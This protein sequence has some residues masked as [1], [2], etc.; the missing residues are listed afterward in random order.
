MSVNIADINQ[1]E[2][3]ENKAMNTTVHCFVLIARKFGVDIS[4][5]RIIHDYALDGEPDTQRLLRIAQEKGFKGLSRKMDWNGLERLGKAFPVLARL[6]NGNSVIIAGCRANESGQ[7]GEPIILILDPLADKADLLHIERDRF[8]ASWSGEIILLKRTYDIKNEERPFG[9]KWFIPE[10]HRQKPLFIQIIIVALILQVL[11]LSSPI[12]FQITFD[13]VIA[14]QSYNT[15]YVLSAGVFIALTFNMIMEYLRGLLLLHATSKIDIRVATRTFSKLLSLPISFFHKISAGVLTKHMQQ[16]STVRDFLT[17]KLFL[18]CLDSLAL[19]VYLPVLFFY[20]AKM[21][22]VVLAFTILISAITLLIATPYRNRLQSL[23]KAEGERQSMLVESISGMETLKSLSVEPMIQHQWDTHSSRSVS[24]SMSVGKISQLVSS[25]TG[26][27][28]KLMSVA[29]IFVGALLVFEGE[30]S[31]G[32]LI[33]FNMLAGK[34]SAP[35]VAMV[36]LVSEYQQTSLSLRML[37]EVMNQKSEGKTNTGLTPLIR[38]SIEFQD[39]T[40][41]YK[42]ESPAA[43]DKMS[44]KVNAGDVIGIVGRSGSG[45]STIIRLLQGLYTLE[46]GLIKV[47]G[48]DLREIEL[49]HF[50]MNT[51]VVLQ[52]SFLFKGSVRDNIAKARPDASFD[53]IIAVARMAGA[54][55]FIQ[56]LSQGYDT[57]LDEGA[58]NLSGGQRQRLSIARTLLRHPKILIFDEATSALDPESEQII[59]HNMPQISAGRTVF[60]AAHRLSTLVN[61]DRILVIDEGEV[62]DFAPHSVLLNRCEL[63]QKLWLSQNT[64]RASNV[65]V[66]I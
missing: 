29:L 20:S 8:E 59:Q 65:K 17:G 3:N 19:V 15:L 55:E 28:E 62:I 54:N 50:R 7:E 27:L 31:L 12:F 53:E 40:F 9:F 42:R 58:T 47:D 43:L 25:V 16:A 11:A 23:Y 49:T 26:Y 34:V 41:R 36:R 56:H 44:F 66:A 57:L 1:L 10:I 37:A 51:G 45:K 35:L 22:Y 64:H 2:T 48:L 52:E 63:Y 60:L 39:V 6:K 30:V 4:P 61:T 21:T 14:N 32:A 5:S 13:K 38:G 33:A 18:T 24:L 46:S